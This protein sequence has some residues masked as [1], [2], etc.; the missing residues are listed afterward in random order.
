MSVAILLL[1]HG[2]AVENSSCFFLGLDAEFVVTV[3]IFLY[4]VQVN[5][6]PDAEGT[7]QEFYL[8]VSVLQLISTRLIYFMGR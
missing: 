6:I 7:F 4:G 2:I 3:D 8:N 1:L 5:T